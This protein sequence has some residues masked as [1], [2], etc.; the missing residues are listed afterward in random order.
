MPELLDASKEYRC[1]YNVDHVLYFH[2]GP[3][4][5]SVAVFGTWPSCSGTKEG[6]EL[7]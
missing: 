4:A 1:L 2:A 7:S 6:L 3:I 5:G